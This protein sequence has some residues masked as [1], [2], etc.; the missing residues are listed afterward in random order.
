MKYLFIGLGSIG[1][2]HLENL[3][4]LTDEPIYA[5]RTKVDEK[6]DK[7]YNIQTVLTVDD[8]M[9]L[10]PDVVF[11]TNPTSKHLDYAMMFNDCHLFI[12][13]PIAVNSHY[14]H[15]L[16][17]SMIKYNKVCFVG[18]NFRFHPQVKQ[19][20]K[21]LNEMKIGRILYANFQSSQYLP[22]WHPKEDY[23][24][25]Y[26]AQRELGGGALLTMSHVIDYAYWLFGKQEVVYSKLEKKSNLEI[27]VEDTVDIITETSDNIIIKIHMDYL[28]KRV[29]SRTIEIV[30][31]DGW[32]T[33]DYYKNELVVYSNKVTERFVTMHFNRNDMYMDELKHF[34]ACVNN[35]E[36]SKITFTDIKD[37]MEII[38][39]AK[40]KSSFSDRNTC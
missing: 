2:Q 13:K 25:S 20:K 8:A 39:E 3:R 24:K 37:V 12:E 40:E 30:G 1:L 11:I 26:A 22:H 29:P 6:V 15:F 34:L 7:K 18:Y 31:E 17:S 35:K 19:I 36:V 10:K 5:L 28:Q 33:W 4:S 23:R 14:L 16:F 27:D 9:K 32:I 38:D 21:L